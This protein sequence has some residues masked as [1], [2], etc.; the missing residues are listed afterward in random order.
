MTQ[1]SVKIE[2]QPAQKKKMNGCL[3]ATMIFVIVCI[4]A[5]GGCFLLGGAALVGS[6]KKQ[7]EEESEKLKSLPNASPSGLQ[8]TGELA[9]LFNLGSDHT[10]IQRKNKEKEIKGQVVDW[11]LSV[12]E[13]SKSGEKYRIQTKSSIGGY[14]NEVA[15][16]V[17]LTAQSQEEVTFIEGLKT[18]D[19][20]R[21]KGCIAGIGMMRTLEIKPAILLNADTA[22]S[23]TGMTATERKVD[24]SLEQGERQLNHEVEQALAIGKAVRDAKDSASEKP[25]PNDVIPGNTLNDLPAEE[26]ANGS[27]DNAAIAQARQELELEKAKL[28]R[29]RIEFEREKLRIQA[30]S[31]PSPSAS[32]PTIEDGEVFVTSITKNDIHN[33]KGVRITDPVLVL[34]QDRA[35]VHRFGNP[36]GDDVD[37]FFR[38]PENRAKIRSYLERGSFPQDVK[39]SILIGKGEKF[40]VRIYKNNVG[41]NC[42]D[43]GF[44]ISQKDSSSIEREDPLELPSKEADR[45]VGSVDLYEIIDSESNIREGPGTNY[46][47]IRKSRKGEVGEHQSVKMGWMKLQFSDDS[48]GWVH[49]QNVKSKN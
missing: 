8:P 17:E 29:E 4:L 41:K 34:M 37:Q 44:Q 25:V 26:G 35:N 22:P 16:F 19:R 15:A 10:D 28:E 32:E 40:R 14:G 2:G 1:E 9:D 31:V 49:E 3:M 5:V 46:P 20:F 30:S 12:Y 33:S 11:T 24:Q 27:I 38:E 6:A 7:A 23:S 42:V 43:V 13:V 48:M 47:I 36:D 18:N 45:N 21:F 39:N